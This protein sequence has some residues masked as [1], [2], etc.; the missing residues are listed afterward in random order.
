MFHFDIEF[1]YLPLFL[2]STCLTVGYQSSFAL[3]EII[4]F[5]NL[6]ILSINIK[7]KFIE[8]FVVFKKW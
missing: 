5:F 4:S 3:T 7:N 2:I 8:K 1:I 6:F